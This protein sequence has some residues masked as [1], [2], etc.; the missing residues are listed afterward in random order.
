VLEGTADLAIGACQS[1]ASRLRH[2]AWHYLRLLTA[3]PIGDLTSGFR[4]YSRA[5][6]RI[7]VSKRATALDYQDIGVLLLLTECGLAIREIPIAMGERV[8][9]KSRV[10]SSWWR[11]ARYMALSSVIGG[12]KRPLRWSRRLKRAA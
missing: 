4:A 3:L 1:R 9:D 6:T 8:G 2:V 7:A 11:V 12:S 5:A 10:F